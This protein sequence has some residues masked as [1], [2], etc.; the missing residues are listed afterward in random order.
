EIESA[1]FA[2]RHT[3]LQGRV[4][5]SKN[6]VGIEQ[7]MWALLTLYQTLRTVMVA[8]AESVPGTDPDRAC[9]SIAV[10]AAR[11]SVVAAAGVVAPTVDLIG[12][13]GRAVL[14]NLLPPRRH[15]FSA[16]KDAERNNLY[17]GVSD[18]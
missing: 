12:D 1:F 7:E 6:P 16:R 15:R 10:H 4:L 8:A 17:I 11:D 5:R 3:L 18:L 2:L 14:T 13:T 9:F